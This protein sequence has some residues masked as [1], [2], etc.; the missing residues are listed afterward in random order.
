MKNKI[1]F[2][3][4]KFNWELGLVVLAFLLFMVFDFGQ[5]ALQPSSAGASSNWYGVTWFG[6]TNLATFWIFFAL[7]NIVLFII[8]GR[9]LRSRKTSYKFDVIFGVIAFIGLLAILGGG[10]GAMYFNGDA[11]LPYIGLQ[12]ITFYHIGVACQLIALLYFILTE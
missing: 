12:Q 5:N 11:V 6:L 8:Y 2:S 4:P 7:Y 1:K 3:L 9:A 10:I